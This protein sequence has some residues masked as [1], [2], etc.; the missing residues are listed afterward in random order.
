M[1]ERNLPQQVVTKRQSSTGMSS[2]NDESESVSEFERLK[3]STWPAVWRKNVSRSYLTDVVVTDLKLLPSLESNLFDFDFASVSLSPSLFLYLL[4]TQEHDD[5]GGGGGVRFNITE[6][7]EENN[8][9]EEAAGG[10]EKQRLHRRDT[11]HHLKNKRINKQVDKEKVA[12][13]IA[14]ALKKQG[15]GGGEGDSNDGSSSA[16]GGDARPPS[17]STNWTSSE[18]N[19]SGAD[20]G[21]GDAGAATD[22][23]LVVEESMI[24]IHIGRGGTSLLTP[25]KSCVNQI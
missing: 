14:Q 4:R 10:E 17:S 7:D 18:L 22:M 25:M 2:E 12:T 24:S 8:H 20:V 3:C 13:I 16:G 11:P 15:G 21:D 6:N 19:Q 9:E 5:S 23:E 1:A